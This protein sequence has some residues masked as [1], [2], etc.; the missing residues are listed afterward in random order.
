MRYTAS[1]KFENV[2]WGHVQETRPLKGAGQ[3]PCNGKDERTVSRVMSESRTA[4]VRRKSAVT[5]RWEP[6]V[7]CQRTTVQWAC[8]PP[9]H[10]LLSTRIL[11]RTAL[12]DPILQIQH[13]SPL[14]VTQKPHR[15]WQGQSVCTVPRLQILRCSQTDCQITKVLWQWSRHSASLHCVWEAQL[16]QLAAGGAEHSEEVGSWCRTASRTLYQLGDAD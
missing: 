3:S 1:A 8:G 9:V 11:F 2:A 14:R 13:P 7:T 16:Q 15:K 5:V 10:G 6:A 12:R 4:K